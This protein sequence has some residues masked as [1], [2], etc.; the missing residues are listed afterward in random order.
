MDKEKYTN[1]ILYLCSKLG[2]RIDGKKK[3]A[4]LLYYV[5]FDHFQYKESFQSITGDT[6][7]A[8]KMGPVP[9]HLDE[10]I[11]Y[12]SQIGKIKVSEIAPYYHLTNSTNVYIAQTAPEVTLFSNDEQLI[13]SGDASRLGHFTGTQLEDLSHSEAPYIATPLGETI[14]YE[15]GLY[16]EEKF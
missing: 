3:L 2:G 1:V 14:D 13:M 8:Q 4:K 9:D 11:D 7:T 15:L 10:I 12:A 16:R 6:Y 5:D